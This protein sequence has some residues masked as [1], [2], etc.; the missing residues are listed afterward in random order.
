MPTEIHGE[1]WL[2]MGEAATYINRSR[3]GL[4][5]AIK[6]YE[7]LTG[8]EVKH[9]DEGQTRLVR[10]SDIDKLLIALRP[11]EARRRGLIKE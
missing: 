1:E 7:K 10:K 3:T 2:S 8:E 5:D 6:R 9:E 4:N 11:N